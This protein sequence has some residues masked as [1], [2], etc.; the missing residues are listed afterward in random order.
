[1][2]ITSLFHR[3]RN[4]SNPG[5]RKVTDGDFEQ[6][7]EEQGGRARRWGLEGTNATHG[8][9]KLTG[10]SRNDG[11]APGLGLN[12]DGASQDQASG[13]RSIEILRLKRPGRATLGSRGRGELTDAVTSFEFRFRCDSR[14]GGASGEI[15]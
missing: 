5:A 15:N 11:I 1:M 2:V 8:V 10:E 14:C 6:G 7:E 9:Y 13:V 12:N 3:V 4:G